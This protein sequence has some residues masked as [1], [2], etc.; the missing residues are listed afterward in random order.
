MEWVKLREAYHHEWILANGLGGYALGY[1]NLLAERKYNC[2]LTAALERFERFQVLNSLEEEVEWQGARF[3]LDSNHYPDCIHPQGYSHIVKTWLRPYP[4][5]LYSSDPISENYLILKE[6]RLIQKANG[7]VVSYTNLGDRPVNLTLR[8]KFSLRDHH[9]L[10]HPGSWDQGGF[11]I[12]VQDRSFSLTREGTGLT[13]RGWLEFGSAVDNPTIFRN[14][15]YPLE[16][17]RGYEAVEDLLSPV[18]LRF[19]LAP[20]QTDRLVVGLDLEEDPFPQA[21]AAQAHY[22]RWPLPT[23]HPLLI[24]DQPEWLKLVLEN[25]RLFSETHYLDILTLAAQDF[26]TEDDMIAGYPWFGPWSRDTLMALDGLDHLKGGKRLAVKI[27]K[28]YGKAVKGG[29]LPNVF[30]E[31]NYGL[32]Y[33]AVDSPL[34]YVLRCYQLAPKDKELFRRCRE[35][36]LGFIFTPDPRLAVGDDG[37]IEIREGDYAL[38]WMDA[39]IYGRPVTPRWGK[40][41]EINA[42]WYNALCSFLEMAGEQGLAEKNTVS[43]KP[44]RISLGGLAEL[45]REVR[46]GLQYFVGDDYLADRLTRVGPVMEVRPNAVVALALPFDW[47]DQETMARVYAKARAELLTP[48]GLRS[49]S[50]V[51]PGFKKKYVGATKQRDLAYHQGTVWAWPLWPLAQLYVKVSR[52]RKTPAE[53][54]KE[55]TGLVWRF[56][57]AFLRNHIASVAEIWD[58]LDPALPKGCPAQAWSVMALLCIEHLIARLERES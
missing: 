10:N 35:I 24:K 6:I 26:L 33:D 53:I 19:T 49:L 36:V 54:A 39:K 42:L 41:V 3:N 8:P 13:A 32:N 15:Y 56:R 12:Q 37:L 16:S 43:L 25:Q 31:G 18:G 52:D 5:V 9:H 29:L 14:V 7:V 58:G 46:R 17:S 22:A 48:K 11:A 38:T 20:G 55:L 50:P 45:A 57:S 51:Q 21:D 34:W 40:P 23:D 27:L 2:L 44:H 28:K 30:G 4:T 1:G 47:L